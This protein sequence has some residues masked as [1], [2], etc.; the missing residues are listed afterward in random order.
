[1]VGASVLAAC[2]DE[3]DGAE[4]PDGIR[5]AA[6]D[7]AESELLAELYAQA[8]E[9][10]GVPVD[11]L[12]VVGPREVVA[13]ALQMGEIDVVPEYVGTAADHY[14]ADGQDLASLRAAVEPLGLE[15][16]DPAEARDENV[17]VVTLQTADLY[18]LVRV[19][20]LADVAPA[21][22]FG[23]PVECPERPLCLL[24]LRDTYG[25]EFAEFVPQ[26]SLTLTADAL[27]RDEIDVGLMFS[28]SAALD[29]DEFVVLED[30][31]GLQPAE[32][33]VPLVRRSAL[34]RW[35]PG[36]RVALDE[37]SA[38]LTTA[39]LRALN[40]RVGEGEA[41][42]RVAATWLESASVGD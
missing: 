23:G 41:V 42:A 40:R 17:F 38:A 7:F 16:L 18:D 20:D 31:R 26:L 24:G 2:G 9:A 4:V 10:N 35:A 30:D 6:F 12:G 3:Q 32:N 21:A 14:G 11:R 13:P 37:V 1:M 29:E 19:S 27:R 25:L 28:T 39:E 8:L 5:V 15:V 22:R 34:D 33:V 36:V